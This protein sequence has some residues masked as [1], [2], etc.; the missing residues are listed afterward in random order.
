MIFDTSQWLALAIVRE[1]ANLVEPDTGQD[2]RA[3]STFSFDLALFQ[4]QCL[5]DPLKEQFD[6]LLAIIVQVVLPRPSL[7]D[8]LNLYC[9]QDKAA[10]TDRDKKR[11]QKI[12]KLRQKRISSRKIGMISPISTRI[13]TQSVRR[14]LR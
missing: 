10:F 6:T 3:I 7:R 2:E 14:N 13:E 12:Y 11:A 8:T 1:V 5:N 4:A 9:A